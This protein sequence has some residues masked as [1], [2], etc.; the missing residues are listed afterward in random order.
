MNYTLDII[1][2]VIIIWGIISGCR[3]GAVTMIVS[4]VCTAA[5]FI[6]ASVVAGSELPERIYE[7]KLS[8]SAEAMIEDALEDGKAKIEQ[9]IRNALKESVENI[10][11]HTGS[12]YIDNAVK[13]GLDEITDIEFDEVLGYVPDFYSYFGVDTETLLTNE[14]IRD[15]IDEAAVTISAY[16]AD[17]I[18]NRLPFGIKISKRK[19]KSVITDPELLGNIINDCIVTSAEENGRDRFA[20][21]T[22]YIE[23]KLVKPTAVRIISNLIWI[24]VFSLVRLVMALILLI[25]RALRKIGTVRTVDSVFGGILGAASGAAAVLVLSAVAFAVVTI[26][27][28]MDFLNEDIIGDTLVFRIFYDLIGRLDI[29]M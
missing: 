16:I 29:F 7:E 11:I 8:Q 5:A 26:T 25:V 28:G 2:A 14:L 4:I 19:V 23:K 9:E 6:I 20:S 15:K 22:L 10:D 17:E 12:D 27:G 24:V 21:S 18:N 1:A 13:E 3:K